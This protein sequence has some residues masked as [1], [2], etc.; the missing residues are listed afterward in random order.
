MALL[1]MVGFV[2]SSLGVSASMTPGRRSGALQG[3]INSAAPDPRAPLRISAPTMASADPLGHALEA[4]EGG[5]HAQRRGQ[6][7]SAPTPIAGSRTETTTWNSGCKSWYRERML[8]T[9]CREP[10]TAPRR[11]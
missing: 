4:P 10:P 1:A 6:R 11:R 5:E 8:P 3:R 7:W 9:A 2:M